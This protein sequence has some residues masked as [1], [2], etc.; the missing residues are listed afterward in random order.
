MIRDISHTEYFSY[1][2]FLIPTIHMHAVYNIGVIFLL[3]SQVHYFGIVDVPMHIKI[4]C[5]PPQTLG[6]CTGGSI[7][8][9]LCC[10]VRMD[11]C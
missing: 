6:A 7:T 3:S 1:R 10:K 2:I 11:V 9:E 8:S 5:F 4:T